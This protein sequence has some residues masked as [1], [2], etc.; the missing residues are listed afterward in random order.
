MNI[1]S[2]IQ[3]I[4]RSTAEIRRI[5]EELVNEI[6]GQETD[7]ETKESLTYMH[8]VLEPLPKEFP[9][10]EPTTTIECEDFYNLCQRYRHCATD[11]PEQVRARYEELIKHIDARY[12][13]LKA[14]RDELLMACQHIRSKI[15]GHVSLSDVDLLDAAIRNATK[16]TP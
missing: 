3:Q 8:G 15:T 16:E 13:A 10:S 4:E 2:E 5:R 14:Q 12:D 6:L 7:M 9:V 11:Q 1:K